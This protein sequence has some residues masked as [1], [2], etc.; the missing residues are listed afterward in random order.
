M[1]KKNLKR[2]FCLLLITQIFGVH[3]AIADTGDT[4]KKL[5]DMRVMSYAILGDYYMFSGLEGD[6]RYSR[7]MN[8]GINAF[9][10]ALTEVT[11]ELNSTEDLAKII[12]QWQSYRNLIETNRS[13]FLAQGYAN[14]RLVGQLGDQAT[15]LNTSLDKAYNDLIDSSQFPVSEWT[16]ITRD[17]GLI[18]V[19]VTAEYSARGTSS[20]G[21]IMTIKINGQ[22]MEQQA[23]LFNTHLEALKK[24]PNQS[25]TIAKS[26][27]QVG[28]KWVFIA[29]SV[30]NYNENSVPFIVNSYGDR[31]S[32]NLKAIGSH[33]S[34]QMQ[35]K[36]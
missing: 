16:Q 6:S 17:M 8:T 7:D 15:E 9:E 29:K 4:L 34:S 25:S 36:K 11:N 19:T 1:I 5:H 21:Q 20:M 18:I 2:I 26:I 35:A 28:V 33:Y 13:D 22:G 32:K 10:E 23:E 24:A 30:A 14:A 27:D 3:S 12:S 31:I